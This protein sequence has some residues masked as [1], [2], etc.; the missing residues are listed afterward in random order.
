[1]NNNQNVTPNEAK[2]DA[3]SLIKKEKTWKIIKY[4]EKTLC[5]RGY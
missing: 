5:E 1:M 2:L 3:A 4:V